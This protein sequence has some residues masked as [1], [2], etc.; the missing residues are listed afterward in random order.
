MRSI[1]SLSLTLSASSSS[2]SDAGTCIPEFSSSFSRLIGSAVSYSSTWRRNSSSMSAGIDSSVVVLPPSLSSSA[3][4]LAMRS[5]WDSSGDSMKVM[6]GSLRLEVKGRGFPLIKW[7]PRIV[8]E[9]LFHAKA[10]SLRRRGRRE[11]PEIRKPE[12]AL[13]LFHSLQ[14]HLVTIVTKLLLFDLFKLLSQFVQLRLSR[15]SLPRRK[16]HRVFNRRVML[17]HAHTR[18]QRFP[19]RLDTIRRDPISLRDRQHVVSDL[20]PTCVLFQ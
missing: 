8:K 15:C 10:N 11:H 19:R 20:A 2:V 6:F 9:K 5:S 16:D 14:R 1:S 4:S 13:D 18:L 17:V 3:R 12:A 7:V